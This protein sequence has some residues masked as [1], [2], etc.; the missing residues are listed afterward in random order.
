MLLECPSHSA[1]LPSLLLAVTPALLLF[2]DA[3]DRSCTR[4]MLRRLR[5]AAAA[6][7]GV[8]AASTADGGGGGGI[9]AGAVADGGVAV[10]G[11]LAESHAATLLQT[12]RA[13]DEQIA[14]AFGRACPGR[15][16]VLDDRTP[17]DEAPAIL[18]QALHV[19]ETSRPWPAALAPAAQP[20]VLVVGAD[21]D[22]VA[23]VGS[24]A[25]AAWGGFEA[26]VAPTAGSDQE[27]DA[28]ASKMAQRMRAAAADGTRCVVC[29]SGA[30]LPVALRTLQALSPGPGQCACTAF[31]LVPAAGGGGGSGVSP[32]AGSVA[33]ANATRDMERVRA[34]LTSSHVTWSTLPAAPKEEALAQAADV[35]VRAV[36]QVPSGGGSLPAAAA[37]ALHSSR[38][39]ASSVAS[40][41]AAL[42]AGAVAHHSKHAERAH[43]SPPLGAAASPP[44]APV[45]APPQGYAAA[46]GS[47]ALT[48][49]SLASSPST[50]SVA[51]SSFATGGAA[52]ASAPVSPLKL[53]PAAAVTAAESLSPP[54]APA[55]GDYI[56]VAEQTTRRRRRPSAVSSW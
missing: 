53:P 32:P 7:G 28:A 12:Y 20:P 6:G 25:Q 31:L 23:A 34:A 35:L 16:C 13:S 26:I 17:S 38:S 42:T 15:L 52:G 2:V 43:P 11:S 14:R 45:Q 37:A 4:R 30:S 9:G 10:V 49:T 47:R 48:P 41:A 44:T 46:P 18:V 36:L 22:A 29:A 40:S 5:A 8:S 21:A 56:G 33:A 27:A 54:M 19:A 1:I 50:V 55:G 51:S 39:V 24:A 3:S